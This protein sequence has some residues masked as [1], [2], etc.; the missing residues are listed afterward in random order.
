MD[1]LTGY[2][3]R[4]PARGED[5]AGARYRQHRCQQATD[6]FF[7]MLAIVQDQEDGA[8]ADGF[9]Q[10]LEGVDLLVLPCD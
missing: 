9:G 6:R 7:H 8:G 1:H 10:M 3:K 5:P 4:H 2:R